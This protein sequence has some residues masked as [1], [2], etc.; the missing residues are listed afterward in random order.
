MLHVHKL[1]S[2]IQALLYNYGDDNINSVR[3]NF[4]NTKMSQAM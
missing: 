4:D 2:D 3:I 1:S